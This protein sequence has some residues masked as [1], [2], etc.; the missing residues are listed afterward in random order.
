LATQGF[1]IMD[2]LD[3]VLNEGGSSFG[4]TW[5]EL[6]SYDAA[7]AAAAMTTT[8][9]S[10]LSGGGG[11]VSEEEDSNNNSLSGLVPPL[12]SANP[13]ASSDPMTAT[14]L[15]SE[16]VLMTS[17]ASASAAATERQSRLSALYGISIEDGSDRSTT[18][19]VV[20]SGGGGSSGNPNGLLAADVLDA[21][22]LL[23]VD[24]FPVTTIAEAD[25]PPHHIPSSSPSGGAVLQDQ[26]VFFAEEVEG[27]GAAGGNE[28]DPEVSFLSDTFG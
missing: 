12:V 23:L 9:Q 7:P 8:L 16:S 25:E 21:D 2:F 11:M 15:P 13:W 3:G 24:L 28:R 20:M 10:V 1:D 14:A 17:A 26:M 27:E 19:G 5:D 4:A 22:D 18:N 6:A